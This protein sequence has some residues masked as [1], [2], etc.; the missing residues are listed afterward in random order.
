MVIT[1]VSHW[2]DHPYP[3]LWQVRCKSLGMTNT[4][5]VPVL[6]LAASEQ[7]EIMRKSRYVPLSHSVKCEQTNDAL[8]L[9]PHLA[10]LGDV[11]ETGRPTY[12]KYPKG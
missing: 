6:A 11:Q 1:D 10:K 2:Y 4:Q 5:E 12:P 9:N 8:P 7:E 3:M